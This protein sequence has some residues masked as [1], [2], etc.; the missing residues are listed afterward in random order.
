MQKSY[1]IKDLEML[2]GIKAHTIRAWESRYDLINPERSDTNIRFYTDKHLKKILNV[3]VLIKGGMKIGRVAKM[4]DEE[5][6]SSVSSVDQI[7]NGFDSQLKR[8]KIAMLEYDEGALNTIL[9]SCVLRYGTDETLDNVV[10]PFIREM[11]MLWQTNAI[12]VSHEHF[13]TSIIKMKLFSLIEHLGSPSSGTSKKVLLFLPGNE[14]HELSLLYLY[15]YLK[16]A[17]Y[18]VLYLGQ[19][20][21]LEYVKEAADK[22]KPDFCV[23]VCTTNP[24]RNDVAA[25]FK[26]IDTLFD[27]IQTPFYFTGGQTALFSE[28]ESPKGIKVIPDLIKLKTDLISA[29][30]PA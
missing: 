2:S 9:N 12:Q 6:S 5:V 7:Q 20:L 16:K 11:G 26:N 1:S 28:V 22:F 4:S 18:K 30:F 3:S 8:L 17:E 14:L 15:Y 13:V 19:S 27:L 10:G 23:S 21:P 25:Y 24:H 29:L